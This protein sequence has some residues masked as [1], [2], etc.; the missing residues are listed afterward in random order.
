[1]TIQ[2]IFC[3]EK[4]TLKGSQCHTF[5][6]EGARRGD[7]TCFASLYDWVLNAVLNASERSR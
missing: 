1:M 3:S 4:Q 2:S 6:A 7:A 5:K